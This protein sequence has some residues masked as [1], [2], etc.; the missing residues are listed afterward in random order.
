MASKYQVSSL[1]F[2]RDPESSALVSVDNNGL[3]AY[4]RRKFL[5]NQRAN[6]IS[7]ISDDINSLKQDFQ[8]IKE[9]LTTLI[10]KR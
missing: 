6:E 7:E 2:N 5:A 1:E 8:E 3:Y 9:L 10:N 4:K